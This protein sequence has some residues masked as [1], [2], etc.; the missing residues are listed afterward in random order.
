MQEVKIKDNNSGNEITP[1]QIAEPKENKT[2]VPFAVAT[3]S[4]FLK[5]DEKTK[6]MFF[7]NFNLLEKV[8]YGIAISV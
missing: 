2:D 8:Y 3:S 4:P 6:R 1:E 5:V 7:S